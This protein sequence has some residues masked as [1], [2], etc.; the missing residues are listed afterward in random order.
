MSTPSATLALHQLAHLYGVQTAYYDVA[1]RRRQASAEALLAALQSLGVPVVTLRD[2][3]S[4]LRER[5]QALWEQTLEPVAVAWGGEP[6]PIEVRLPSHTADGPLVGHLTLET[7]E[8][9]SWK[10][11]GADLPVLEAIEKEGT[12]YVVK[13]IPLPAGL[14]WGYHR[15][16][17][18]VSGKPVEALIIAAPF[19]AYTH[20]EGPTSRT[21]GV[22]L[23]LYALY[24]HKSWG[25]GDLSDLEAL[26]A[27]VAGMGGGA[28]ATLPILAAF[29]DEPF[30]PS[31]Y[32]PASRLLWNESY[33]D[34]NRVPELQKCP[35][36]QAVLASSPFQ[37]EIESLRSLPLVDYRRLMA[38]KRQILQELARCCFA[39]ASDRLNALLR[40]AE[41]HPVVQDYARFRATCERRRVSWRSW[42]RPLREGIL[43]EGDYDEEARRYHL[44]VQ[45]LAHQQVQALSE[46]ARENGPG[47]YL[48]LPLGVHPDGYDAWR[49]QDLFVHEASVGAPPDA[50]F[51]RGQD[52]VLPPLHPERLRQQY[53]SYYIAYL[54]HH[55]RHAGILRIDH[56]MGFHRLFWIPKGMEASQGIYVR[57]P[58][59][60]FYAILA[61][62]SHRN[63]TIIVGEDMGTVPPYVRP[64]MARHGLHRMYVVQYELDEL[65]SHPQT[66]LRRVPSNAVAGINTHDM[67][68]FRRFWQGLDIHDR[69]EMGLLT[70]A[71]AQQELVRRRA[72]KQALV[73]FLQHRGYI[74][75]P[76]SDPTDVL[77]ATLLFLSASS[78]P[79]VIVNL[80]DLW[81]DIQPQNV[82]GTQDER[83]NWRRKARYSFEAFSRM[84]EV[85]A[86]V[87]ELD[88]I[89]KH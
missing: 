23:P 6:P 26:I 41:A 8:R 66:A 20:A 73:G 21:W 88:Y 68:P 63:K 74:K 84:P 76:A 46:R 33:L 24:T 22:F 35:S 70:E 89:R 16:T 45:W 57:Y 28:V 4:A 51:T 69:Q 25:S 18:E 77:K 49:K 39:E 82:P 67:P 56:A 19:K 61:L 38:L 29:L 13:R 58:A 12:Q 40:F 64:A 54:R 87:Q 1:R 43:R 83:P 36:A 2:V 15:F 27:W 32:A 59:E 62:E 81:G 7:G 79:A 53:Y 60:E 37:R 17:L 30:E 80:E 34:V 47:L 5:Q 55:L 31:P 11:H 78:A 50:V 86:T 14:P 52:W 85:V 75:G 44:Y 71:A 10:W 42:P 72:L 65:A 9:Q 3:P 48:D